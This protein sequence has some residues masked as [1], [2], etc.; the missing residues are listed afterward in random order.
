MNEQT[1][2]FV[3]HQARLKCLFNEFMNPNR[4]QDLIPYRFMNGC[5]LRLTL[6]YDTMELS[7]V[8]NGEI[9]ESKPGYIFYVKPDVNEPDVNYTQPRQPPKE[10]SYRIITFRDISVDTPSSIQKYMNPTLKIV[11]YLIRHGQGTHNVTSGTTKKYNQV[12]GEAD[13]E[14]TNIGIQQASDVGDKL[15][16][17]LKD[18]NTV[19]HIFVSDLIRTQ[20]TAATIYKQLSSKE[21]N[22]TKMLVVIPCSHELTYSGQGCDGNQWSVPRENMTKCIQ[23]KDCQKIVYDIP[24]DWSVYNAFYNGTRRSHTSDNKCRTTNM[25]VSS[26]AYSVG[27]TTPDFI[28]NTPSNDLGDTTQQALIQNNPGIYPSNVLGE[29]TQ[30]ALIQN[31]PGIYLGGYTKRKKRNTKR[32]KRNTKRKKRN[33]RQRT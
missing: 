23:I 28:Q 32:K 26:V 11:Y 19:D 17:L 16:V 9:D 10:S 6:M 29:T 14:L 1:C 27:Q 7:L 12:F 30:Q 31:N 5:V 3:T 15:A 24:V 18:S 21:V 13:A 25:I 8:D 20:Q 2:L 33:T 4:I 22:V